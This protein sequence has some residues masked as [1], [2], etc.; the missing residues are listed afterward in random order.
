MRSVVPE[1]VVGAGPPNYC[2]CRTDQGGLQ[3]AAGI[4][5]RGLDSGVQ[6]LQRPLQVYLTA[7]VA[8]SQ[9]MAGGRG[10]SDFAIFGT[11]RGREV[12]NGGFL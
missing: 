10:W 11:V 2:L 7:S 3:K 4:L 6:V 8:A 9:H 12:D 5:K 1:G